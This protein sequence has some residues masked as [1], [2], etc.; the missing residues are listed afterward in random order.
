MYLRPV[1]ARAVEPGPVSKVSTYWCEQYRKKHGV[2]YPTIGRH[3]WINLERIVK[4]H[5]LEKTR[6]WIWKFMT[7]EDPW[8]AGQGWN[9]YSFTARIPK[10]QILGKERKLELEKEQFAKAVEKNPQLDKVAPR[11]KPPNR[12]QRWPTE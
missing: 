3:E 2:P 8:V 1:Q 12:T 6:W 5:G 10:L 11:S 7:M 9:I 4:M